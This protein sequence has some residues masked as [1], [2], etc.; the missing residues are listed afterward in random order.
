[1]IQDEIMFH[2]HQNVRSN[3]PRT[4]EVTRHENLTLRGDCIIGVR[5][6]KACSTLKENLKNRLRIED[7]VVTMEIIVGNDS[8]RIDGSGSG[9]LTLEHAH[10][11][12]LRKSSFV[13]PRTISVRCDKGS[14]EIPRKIIS[15]LQ[16]PE[17]VALLRITV[18]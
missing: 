2:G 3:H 12:V 16:N 11:V 7:S 13:C 15:G 18:E 4:I 17:T 9:Q 10:D 8:C 5:A 6:N 1:M 14:N